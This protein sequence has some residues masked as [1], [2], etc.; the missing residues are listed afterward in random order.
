M[1]SFILSIYVLQ[2][3]RDKLERYFL[4]QTFKKKISCFVIDG[5]N[6]MVFEFPDL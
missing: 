3:S 1:L 5:S 4:V 6:L 2:S